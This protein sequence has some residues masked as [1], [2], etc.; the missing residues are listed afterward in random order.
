MKKLLISL[1]IIGSITFVPA[2]ATSQTIPLPAL[3]TATT[4]IAGYIQEYATEYSVSASLLNRVILCES[5]GD[6]TA[7]SPTKD[8]G[9]AQ[10]NIASWGISKE[11]AFD[12]D[13][14]IKFMAHQF[15][16]GGAHWWVCYKKLSTDTLTNHTPGYILHHTETKESPTERSMQSAQ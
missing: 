13:F 7:V 16:I 12:P 5:G 11:Q 6:P 9:V 3:P 15:S 10:I 14:S 8:Y 2:R 1:A 4:T